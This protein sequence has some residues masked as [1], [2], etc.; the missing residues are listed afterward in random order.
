MQK[1]MSPKYKMKLIKEVE[2]A[3]CKEYSSF[4]DREYYI[5]QWYENDINWSNF[6]IIKK[7][8]MCDVYATI[9]TMD[10]ATLV[11]VAID[12]GV[13]TPDFIP[14]I[15]T[16]RNAIKSDYSNASLTFEKA[17]KQLTEHP[18]IAIGLVNSALESIIKEILKDER[19]STQV[20][21]NDT[22]YDL[23]KE[24]LKFF[25]LYPYSK[26]LPELKTIGS[27]FIAI[28]QS[29]EK[30]RSEKTYFHGKSSGDYVVDDTLFAYFVV[31]SV[32]TVG[33]FLDSYY[34]KMFPVNKK[35]QD[36]TFDDLPF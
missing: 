15:P 26:M 5:N 6:E 23:T 32:A 28:N 9:S 12:M 19:I 20:N 36:N 35:D 4:I 16:F 27:S 13:E 25:S 1:I 10:D 34:K 17:F 31:N 7:A 8:G 22:L 29:I 33:L 2:A 21:K 3:I 24:I 11:K 30:L 18:D 14:S